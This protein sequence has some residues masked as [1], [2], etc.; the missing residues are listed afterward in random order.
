MSGRPASR[1]DDTGAEQPGPGKVD[2]VVARDLQERKNF[3]LFVF[4]TSGY[5]LCLPRCR[6]ARKCAPVYF[7]A[8]R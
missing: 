4:T 7:W 8:F 5:T 3:E 1:E 2:P 6:G